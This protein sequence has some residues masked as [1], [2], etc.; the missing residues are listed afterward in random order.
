MG[1]SVEKKGSQKGSE[2][3]KLVGEAF[4]YLNFEVEQLGQG[5]GREP[6]AIIKFPE[7][8]IAF[9]VDAKAYASGYTLGTDDRAIKEYISYYCPKL[10]QGGFN[11][12]GFII[13]SNSFK[14]DLNDLIN[15][16]TWTTDVKRFLQL[17]TEALLY[18][19]AYKTKDK[20]TLSQII[21]TLITFNSVITKDR[22][23]EEFGDY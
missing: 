7:E 12:I 3:E 23:I 6:D 14:T 18:L 21:E 4:K 2:F 20:L 22:I 13:V 17:T 19:L 11:K 16:I 10:K 1:A 15:E 9:I 8:H 5:T